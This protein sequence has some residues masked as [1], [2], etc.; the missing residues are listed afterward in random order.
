MSDTDAAQSDAVVQ[1]EIGRRKALM[2]R[3]LASGA[4][5]VAGARLFDVARNRILAG[6]RSRHPDWPADRIEREFRRL[7]ALVRQR[8]E[9]GIFKP[10]GTS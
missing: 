10:F 8:E 4:K 6:I 3:T 7:L 9:R 5:L 2:A 1:R